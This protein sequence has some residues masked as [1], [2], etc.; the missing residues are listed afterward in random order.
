GAGSK[1]R[2][3]IPCGA[4]GAPLSSVE[5]RH[6]TDKKFRGHG[7]RQIRGPA[8]ATAGT[9]SAV[10]IESAA[11][12]RPLHR[13]AMA[14][15][16]RL[17]RR[18]WTPHPI[19]RRCEPWRAFASRCAPLFRWH[20]PCS[21]GESLA[22]ARGAS[23]QQEGRKM[24]SITRSTGARVV[25]ALSLALLLGVREARAVKVDFLWVIDNSPSMTDKQAVLSMAA[26]NIADE[27]AHATC[28]IDWRMA[29]TYTDLYVPA[30]S[31]DV[32]SG[33][34]GPG[35]RVLCPFTDR[36]STRLN[37]SHVSISYAVFC[38]KK[39]K[40]KIRHRDTR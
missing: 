17:A 14:P 8:N 40:Q 25:A 3:F 20:P 21:C 38:L 28:P 6:R 4:L 12:A 2:Q 32:C 35:R 10:R 30:S 27:L 29:V 7:L 9:T 23:R 13:A 36:K 22:G 1:A 19:M 37:S 34:P 5:G 24:K 15:H 11:A 31:N 39:K 33:A 26:T 16:M 18:A